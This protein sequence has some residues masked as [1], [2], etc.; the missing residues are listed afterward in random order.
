MGF[1]KFIL[2]WKVLLLIILLIFSITIINPK[3]TSNCIVVTSVGEGAFYN[4]IEQGTIICS[5]KMLGTKE[6]KKISDISDLLYFQ[7]KKGYLIIYTDKG[8]KN[9][10]LSGN[11]IFNI[12]ADKIPSSNLRFGLDIEGGIRALLK[13]ED[14]NVSINEIIDI[15]ETR[16]NVYGLRQAEFRKVTIGDEKLVMVSI[17]GGTKE[18]IKKLL[19][20]E[21]KFEAKIPLTIENN[22]EVYFGKYVD[23]ENEVFKVY[24]LNSTSIKINNKIIDINE[25]FKL[26]NI[27]FDIKNITSDKVIINGVVYTDKDIKGIGIPPESNY[28]GKFGE[29]YQYRFGVVISQEG[30]KKF[31]ELTQN[32][33]R[34]YTGKESYL[35]EKIYFYLDEKETNALNIAG[36]L[37]GKEITNPVITGWGKTEEEAIKDRDSLKAILKSGK[38]PTKIEI[39]SIDQLSASVG[40][41]YLYIILLAGISAILLVSFVI[42]LRYKNWKISLGIIATM[43]SEVILILGFAALTHWN[44]STLAL[45][46]IVAAI[47]FGVDDQILIIDETI[48]KKEKYTII[49]GLKRAFF[50][51]F[52]SGLTTIFAMIPILT[53]GFGTFKEIGGFAITT[54]VGVLIGIFITRPAFAKYVEYILS[55]E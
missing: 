24:I 53:I 5:A 12:S 46:G 54:I 51:I 3:P 25:K 29:G 37:K 47:G 40:K 18:E 31:A 36:D 43:V 15:L 42:F 48:K 9:I 23:K 10:K 30:A 19:S 45:A 6:E 1:K 34:I 52:G 44:L 8:S 55:A 33:K 49:E 27:E 22:S 14:T 16:V 20:R 41:N 26:K 38:L 28:L 35:S 2:N 11:N 32:L 4:K 7:N 50:M 13:P 17:A 39:V 21:G